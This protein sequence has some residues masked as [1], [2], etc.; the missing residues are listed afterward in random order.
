M[1][2]KKKSQVK[3]SKE[4]WPEL[5]EVSMIISLKT[6]GM[7]NKESGKV[8]SKSIYKAQTILENVVHI[9]KQSI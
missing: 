7:I 8:K 9:L 3:T 1:A 4:R 5:Y 2:K 6:I